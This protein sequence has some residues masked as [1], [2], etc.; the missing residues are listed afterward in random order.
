MA[1]ID[2]L[3]NVA[4]DLGTTA[5][6]GKSFSDLLILGKHKMPR[7]TNRVLIL[8]DAND[9]LDMGLSSTDPL[10]VAVA[11]A[12]SQVT[13]ISQVYVG[14]IGDSETVAE[15]LA[16]CAKENNNWYGLALASRVEDEVLLAA[17][18]AEANQKLFVTSSN[19]AGIIDAGEESDLASQFKT[20]N[21]FRSTVIY[22]HKADVEYPE[23]AWMSYC[24]TFYPGSETWANKKLSGVS[25]SPLAEAEFAA[26]KKKNASSFENFNDSFS[27]T[28]GGKVAGGEWIDIIRFRDWLVQEIQINVTSTL[29]NTYGKVPYTDQGIEL[30]GQSVRKALDLGIERG[31]IAPLEYDNDKNEIPS[32]ILSLP[33]SANVSD[34]N[35]ANRILQDVK[36]KARLAGAIHLAEIKGSLGYS[37]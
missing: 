22:S 17:A 8:T 9:L 37:M 13:H 12:F 28:Q 10:Y 6:A 23:V 27:I 18:W 30:I 32:Y 3:A 33:K 21:F 2:R 26:L 25:H 29:I 11:T 19:A 7:V 1:K 15:A 4:I 36:F 35:K 20:K 16:A 24:F 5:I 14:N 34:N 31:G